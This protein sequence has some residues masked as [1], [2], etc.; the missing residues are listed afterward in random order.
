MNSQRK[1]PGGLN[2]FVKGIRSIIDG[3]YEKPRL[4]IK[5]EIQALPSSTNAGTL[6]MIGAA[7]DYAI[8][9]EVSKINQTIVKNFPIIAEKG[10]K[11]YK[12]RRQFIEDF[13]IKRSKFISDEIPITELLSDCIVLARLDN[14][15]RSTGNYSPTNSELF[16]VNELYITD[17]H[18]LINLVDPS[19]FRAS[20]QCI[21]N[22]HFGQSSIDVGGADADLIIDDLLIDIKTTKDINFKLEY[23]RQLIGYYT[24]NR[25]EYDMYGKI[26]RLGLYFSRFGQ[27]LTFKVPERKVSTLAN[28]NLTFE[29]CIEKAIEIWNNPDSWE[30]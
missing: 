24:L 2:E 25:R 15:A 6:S 13:Q 5:S 8:R 27:L 7:F 28:T 18:N 10:V 1:T 4:S 23:F 12:K 17:L 21:L 3:F 20:Y 30:E 14:V 19:L 11:G 9:I 16:D 22:P 26:E 29:E